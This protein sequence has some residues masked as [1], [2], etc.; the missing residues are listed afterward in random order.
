MAGRRAL[1]V[2]SNPLRIL[3]NHRTRAR[4]GQSVHIEELIEA[5]RAEGHR[6]E[7]VGPS[8]VEALGH[9]RER[10]LLPPA[11]YEIAELCYS[12]V[13][14]F[15]LFS[16]A[17]RVKPDLIYQRANLHMIG[18]AWLARLLGVPLF[19]EVNAPLADERA[20]FGG[21]TWPRLARWSERLAWRQASRVLPVSHVLARYLEKAGVP[22]GNISVIANG[23]D[24]RRFRPMDRARAKQLLDLD[25]KLVLGFIGYVREW[26][27]LEQVIDLMASDPNLA[28]GHLLVVGDG[29]ARGALTRRAASHGI[30]HKLY[31]TGVV[32]REDVVGIAAS[33]D[34]ALQPDVTAY[35]SPLKLME[36][37][38]LGHAIAAP[39]RPNIRE[40]VG[41]DEDALLFD[42]EDQ[43]AFG[44]CVAHLAADRALRERLGQ[45]A[46][47]A[48]ARKERTWKGNARRIAALAAETAQ[49]PQ[50]LRQPALS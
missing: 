29:P 24:N 35:A 6:V 49:K 1:N 5:F 20:R 38:A 11:L 42:P 22:G 34:I 8:Q 28:N 30:A 25:G 45:A 16:A 15:R 41:H 32:R 7:V 2:A 27:G 18:T 36:Y 10:D 17:C 4:D 40:L 47:A 43:A 19:L 3:Y 9:G 50:V 39:D 23:V 14:F 46:A 12:A 21:L 44:R 26:H 48:I 33:F 31:F 37:M 13:E